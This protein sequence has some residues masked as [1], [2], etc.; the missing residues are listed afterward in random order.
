MVQITRYLWLSFGVFVLCFVCE[1]LVNATASLSGQDQ[2]AIRRQVIT[3]SSD[4]SVLLTQE[5]TLFL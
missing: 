4:A 5:N 3:G 1:F 2:N